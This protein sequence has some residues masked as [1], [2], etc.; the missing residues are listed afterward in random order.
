MVV[1]QSKGF[2]G[3]RQN[4]IFPIPAPPQLY[5]RRAHFG[6]LEDGR[7]SESSKMTEIF[8][9]S[10]LQYGFC[11]IRDLKREKRSQFLEVTYLIVAINVL[12]RC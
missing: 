1:G 8:F 6:A 12:C 7:Q 9:T 11:H 4:R 5:E 3:R 10:T 2:K